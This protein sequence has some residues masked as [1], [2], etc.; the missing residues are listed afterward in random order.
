MFASE[1]HWVKLQEKGRDSEA[2]AK[3]FYRADF[4]PSTQEILGILLSL[5]TVKWKWSRSVMSD[6]LQPHEL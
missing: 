1:G 5:L 6:S 3:S 2:T 4:S